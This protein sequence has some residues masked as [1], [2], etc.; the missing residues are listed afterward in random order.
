MTQDEARRSV[1]QYWMRKA[2]D[3]L[4]SA[5]SEFSAGRTDFA[6]NRSYYACFY[7]ASA[8]LLMFGKKFVKHK[9]LTILFPIAAA[10]HRSRSIRE[11]PDRARGAL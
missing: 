6:V 2:D 7:A 10:E 1:V 9:C 4:A 3:A 8:Y 11:T 5:H